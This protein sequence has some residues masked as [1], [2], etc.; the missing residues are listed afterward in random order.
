MHDSNLNN[1]FFF[2]KKNI[3]NK[4][5]P[6]P[7][8]NNSDLFNFINSSFNTDINSFVKFNNQSYNL[9]KKSLNNHNIMN[10]NISQTKNLINKT[11]PFDNFDFNKILK[12]NMNK[13]YDLIKNTIQ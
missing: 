6:I 9:E 5:E 10:L 13:S 1:N 7:N 11:G 2:N 3:L 8:Q 4:S 12:F